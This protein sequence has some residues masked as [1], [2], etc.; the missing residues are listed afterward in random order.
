MAVQPNGL[1][2]VAGC[3]QE[4]SSFR[5]SYPAYDEGRA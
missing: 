4:F 2:T 1:C 3:G 5:L